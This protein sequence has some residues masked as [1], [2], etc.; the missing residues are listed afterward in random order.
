MS[1]GLAIAAPPVKADELLRDASLAMRQ[2]A[3]QGRDCCVVAQPQ[4]SDEPRRAL[5]LRAEIRAALEAE[6]FEAWFMPV[7]DLA[8]SELRGYEALV[9]WVRADGSVVLPDVFLPT[10]RRGNLAV[11]IDL[12]V[13]RR[14]IAALASLPSECFV[15]ANVTPATLGHTDLAA[16]VSRWLEEE[17]GRAHV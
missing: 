5:T 14:S 6:G 17:I 7:V 8:T 13:L 9:R 3:A 2:A 1:I 15:A 11:E 4:L 10:A 16:L 12:Q